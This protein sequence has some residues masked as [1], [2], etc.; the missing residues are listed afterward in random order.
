M[1]LT[2][3]LQLPLKAVEKLKERHNKISQF[4]NGEIH[5]PSMQMSTN[6]TK[7]LTLTNIL[8]FVLGVVIGLYAAYLS[9]QCNSKLSYSTFLKVIFSV[10]AYLFGLVYLILYLVMRWDTCKRI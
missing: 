5:T 8:T 10:F 4:T 3:A 1:D 6:A 7:S 2:L 9:W